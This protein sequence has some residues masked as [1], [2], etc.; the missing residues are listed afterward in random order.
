MLAHN[1]VQRCS[2]RNGELTK[3]AVVGLANTNVGQLHGPAETEKL[4]AIARGNLLSAHGALG[5]DSVVEARDQLAKEQTALVAVR[6]FDLGTRNSLP[7]GFVAIVPPQKSAF[8]IR[9]HGLQLVG[10]LLQDAANFSFDNDARK[11]GVEPFES[12]H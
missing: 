8:Q 3:F 6:Q 12:F 1:L 4:G 10:V 11:S 9:I 5:N 2:L 7:G